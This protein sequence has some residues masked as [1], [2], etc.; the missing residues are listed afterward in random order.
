M[1]AP[2]SCGRPCVASR[3]IER[4]WCQP[5]CATHCDGQRNSSSAERVWR[6][7]SCSGS[8]TQIAKLL[9]RPGWP[10]GTA[11]LEGGETY[12]RRRK[13]VDRTH[14]KSWPHNRA[15]TLSELFQQRPRLAQIRHVEPLGEPAV[16]LSQHLA[17]FGSTRILWFVPVLEQP[18]Q[19]DRGAQL[20]PP[21]A[22][23]PGHGDRTAETCLGGLR[24]RQGIR[25]SAF[26]G[27]ANQQQLAR[28]AGALPLRAYRRR[29]DPSKST[30]HPA[31]P[32]PL[33]PCLLG[34]SPAPEARAAQHGRAG[35]PP[36]EKPPALG[37]FVAGFLRSDFLQRNSG[38]PDYQPR[39]QRTNPLRLIDAEHP[40]V[41]WRPLHPGLSQKGPCQPYRASKPG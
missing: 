41:I 16:D 2:L 23:L 39:V 35:S 22:L 9:C 28:A 4:V 27:S 15:L 34:Y 11:I 3:G 6:F 12:R 13:T 26:Q 24:N 36:S 20:P 29:F 40:L 5:L 33:P 37:A 38:R 7:A 8:L 32:S 25:V 17:S 31:Q 1:T 14:R 10:A 21:S 19:A 18:A 30:L